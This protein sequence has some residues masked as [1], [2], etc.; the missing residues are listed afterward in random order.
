M[1]FCP[2]VNRSSVRT[3]IPHLPIPRWCPKLRLALCLGCMQVQGA[4]IGC[5][6]Q[7]APAPFASGT[8]A[9]VCQKAHSTVSVS[10]Q[11]VQGWLAVWAKPS[12]AL[13]PNHHE[14]TILDAPP[15]Q[16]RGLEAFSSAV[17]QSV[18]NRPCPALCS[19]A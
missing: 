5:A 3:S 8:G 6:C 12:I 15:A 18:T 10:V 16:T 1:L 7:K 4:H 14:G 19:L 13:F 11:C 17:G 9:R 2:W